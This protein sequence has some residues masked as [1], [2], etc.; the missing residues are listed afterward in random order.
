MNFNW[1]WLPSG[2]YG[3]RRAWR[4]Q[5]PAETLRRRVAGAV[6]LGCHPGPHTVLSEEEGSRIVEY[7]VN[8]SDIGFG[9][10]REDVM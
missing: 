4:L 7:V 6:P 9:L 5:V 8:M 3:Q 1:S 2:N 10:T